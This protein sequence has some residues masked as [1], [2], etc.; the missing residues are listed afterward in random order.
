[1][2]TRNLTIVKNKGEYKIAQYGQWDGFINGNGKIILNFLLTADL[3]LF[4]EKLDKVRFINA[5]KRLEIEKFMKKIGSLNGSMDL[6]QNREFKKKYFQL[7]RDC[8]AGILQMVLDS[9]EE[10]FWVGNDIEP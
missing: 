2:E 5:K 4:K 9:D 3:N 7:S 6:N 8:G 10:E 1:M